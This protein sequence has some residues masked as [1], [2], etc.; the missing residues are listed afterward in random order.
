MPYSQP[1]RPEDDTIVL[2]LR[3]ER[4]T[5]TKEIT[6]F[7]EYSF[8]SHFLT[9]T[10]HFSFT[11]GDEQLKSSIL[12]GIFIGQ[13]VT[14]Q[15][16][17]YVQSGGFID[18]MPLKTSRKGG[19][20]LHVEGR[21]WLSPAVDANM[22]PMKVRFKAGQSLLDV[23][24]ESFAPYGFGGIGQIVAS[25]EANANIITG[26]TRGNPTSKKGKPL[27]SFQIHQL[28][29]Y[30]HE[31]VFAFA[32]RLSQRFGLW[33]WPAANGETLIVDAPD[34]DQKAIYDIRNKGEE[35]TNY[36]TGEI[37]PNG[38]NQ[39]TVIFA[40]GFG[41]GGEYP[42][43]G[44]RVAMVNEITGLDERG[45]MRAEV[46]DLIGANPD[47]TL[48]P[49]RQTLG[50]VWMPNA[51]VRAVYLHDDESKTQEQ[52]EAFVRREMA[53][54]QQNAVVVRYS[55]EGHT[56]RGIP[57]YTNSVANIDDD[58]LGVHDR[59]WCISRNF[60]KSRGGG[61]STSTEWIMPGTLDFGG[62]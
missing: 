54:R 12:D 22:D 10:D 59:M 15:I 38:E 6:N 47:A 58:A 50:K 4:G 11:I 19:T 23:L 62:E 34:F 13:Q 28:K 27:K 35:D 5:V 42:R 30:P 24:R 44:M 29:P 14:L 45:W 7:R 2:Q 43:A 48:L 9:P 31:G 37:D 41:G 21:D 20:E 25:D 51:R 32:S 16:S 60:T 33:I 39:P 26:Q 52:L 49:V 46:S 55:F 61:T 17:G 40:T 36:E 56:L 57:W 8:N 1:M 53:L 18:R 3:D